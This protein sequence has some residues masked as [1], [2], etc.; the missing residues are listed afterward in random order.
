M[1]KYIKS[2]EDQ[3]D[4]LKDKLAKADVRI[5][6]LEQAVK[7]RMSFTISI[8]MRIKGHLIGVDWMGGIRYTTQQAAMVHLKKFW[9]MYRKDFKNR[10]E[11]DG[12]E[13]KYFSISGM[14]VVDK[15][16]T[17]DDDTA[18]LGPDWSFE[19]KDELIKLMKEAKQ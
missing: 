17:K 16:A 6:E 8:F 19:T 18:T 9:N 15:P 13:F 3:N 7:F 2:I 12:F 4:K 10:F 14:Y 11:P 5:E 1:K